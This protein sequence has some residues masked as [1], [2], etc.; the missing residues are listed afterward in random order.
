MSRSYRVVSYDAKKYGPPGSAGRASRSDR[1]VALDLA[2]ELLQEDPP[3]G[4]ELAA[5][6]VAAIGRQPAAERVA[7][8]VGKI[9]GSIAPG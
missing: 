7:R 4:D 5:G 6:P 3:P 9:I 1:P 8:G 2:E